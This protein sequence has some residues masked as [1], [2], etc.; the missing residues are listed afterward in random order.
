M[1]ER[2]DETLSEPLYAQLR[3]ILKAR[4]E[5]G[6]YPVGRRIPSEDQLNAQFGVSRIT[7][8]RALSELANEGYLIKRAGKGSYVSDSWVKF[9]APSKVSVRF[10]QNNDVQA[11]S[12]SCIANGFT[13]GATL[14]R[15]AK[16]PGI[17]SERSFFGF[18]PEDDLLLVE[19]V[20]TA[21]DL[22]I[23]VEENLFPYEPYG[24]IENEDLSDA[25]LYELILR[26]G[27]TEPCLREPCALELE[28]CSL[29]Y[30][31]ILKVPAGE[32]LF[33]LTGR[34]YDSEG[35]PMYFGKQHIVGTRYT[36]RI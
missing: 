10:P 19:R 30:A 29:N 5:Q 22:P 15:C 9:H 36:F 20:R 6:L 21:D 11:F 24:F 7:V 12:E 33:C 1:E 35:H 14:I 32:P 2:I 4:I 23:M 25:S 13:P 31:K 18:G 3:D 34:Y 8:R 27:C 28:K 17:E 16:I 26:H